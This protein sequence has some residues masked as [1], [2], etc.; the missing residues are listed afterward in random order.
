MRIPDGKQN[1]TEMQPQIRQVCAQNSMGQR[2][3]IS[4]IARGLTG[5]Q[6]SELCYVNTTYLRQIEAGRK[7]PSLPVFISLCNVLKVSPTY[8][9]EDTLSVNELSEFETLSVLWKKASPQQIEVV[10]AMLHSALEYL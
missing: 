7:V 4:R 2:I 5:D 9:L 1:K 3:K 6:L 10:T 8:L